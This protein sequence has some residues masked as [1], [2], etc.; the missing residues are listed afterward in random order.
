MVRYY[1]LRRVPLV[2][3]PSAKPKI[4]PLPRAW[5][6][7]EY[8]HLQDLTPLATA[9]RETA[10]KDFFVRTPWIESNR[11]EK[12]RPKIEFSKLPFK[13]I[14]QRITPR[15]L[16]REFGNNPPLPVDTPIG[17]RLTHAVLTRSTAAPPRPRD[18]CPNDC[19]MVTQNAHGLKRPHKLESVIDQMIERNLQAY[20][21]QET[22]LIGDWTKTVKGY[23][24]FHH[25]LPTAS[26][27]R[28]SC[29]VMIILSP[30]LIKA[31]EREGSPPPITA[32]GDT[33]A[34]GR[35]IGVT[36]SFPRFDLQ[37]RKLKGK[38]K[39]L[40]TSAYHPVE[41]SEQI[42]FND[43]LSVFFSNAPQNAE[44]LTGCD[45]NANVGIRST[46]FN[47]EIGPFGL[48]N[49]NAKGV[50]LNN[51]LKFHNF[52]ILLSF[53]Q[54]KNYVT[55]KSFG[56]KPSGH[57]LDNWICC[58]KFRKRVINCSVIDYGVESDHSA[59]IVLFR[60]KAIKF[61]RT[62]KLKKAINWR[63]LATDQVVK[64]D[65]N[66]RLKE[67]LTLC[68]Q[69]R[70]E[71]DLAYHEY[72][73]CIVQAAR[74]TA[75]AKKK[76][77]KGWYDHSRTYLTP[78]IGD[79]TRLLNMIRNSHD[80]SE[81]TIIFLKGMLKQAQQKVHD[82][83]ALAKAKWSTVQ[84][85]K[86][87]NM[88]RNPKDAWQ[89]IKVI[90]AGLTGHHVHPT[91]MRMKMPTGK[92]AT[93][94]KEN[95]SI[96]GPH[97]DKVYNAKRPVDWEY[98]R[99]MKKRKK[100]WKLDAQITWDEFKQAINDLSYDKAA[101]LNKV[102]P[103]ALKALVNENLTYLFEFCRSFYADKKD[104]DEWHESQVCPLPKPGK[105]TSDPNNWRGI[106]LMDMG[107]KVFSSMMCKRAFVLIRKYG[108]K[109]QFGSTPNV[110][111]QDG[112][113]CIKTMLH[114][115]HQHNLPTFVMFADLVKAF[116]TANHELLMEILDTYG[117]PPKFVSAIKRMY[118]NTKVRLIIGKIDTSIP[119]TVGVKQGDS[120]A[121]VLFL[122]L[123]MAF[124]E[125]LEKEWDK[126]KLT[127]P[128]FSRHD[129]SPHTSAQLTAHSLSKPNSPSITR[130]HLFCML[131]VDDGAFTFVSRRELE[132]GAKLIFQQFQKFGLEMHIGRGSKS[133]KTECI[134]FPEPGRF[135]APRL[136]D[137]TPNTLSHLSEATDKKKQENSV[138]KR[139]REDSEYTS[140]AETADIW[141]AD[142][143]I[144][145]TQ[146]FKYL[147]SWLSY[148][149]GDDHDV[150]ERIASANK[151][152]GALRWFWKDTKVD[153]HSKFLTFIAIPLNLLLWGCE[154]W[155]LKSTLLASLEVFLHRSIRSI[156]G[157]TMLQVRE[158]RMSNKK[159]RK[160]FYNILTIQE[161]IAKRQLTFI[162]KITRRDRTHIPTL[163]LT[164]WSENPRKRGGI[165]K[166]NRKSIVENLQLLLPDKIP[167]TGALNTWVHLAQDKHYWNHL[168]GRLGS[169]EDSTPPRTSPSPPSPNHRQ[170]SPPA[171]P[172]AR[173]PASP[174]PPVPPPVPSPPH[175]QHRSPP[176]AP[177]SP[178]PFANSRSRPT[179]D[180]AQV[181]KTKR[182][183]LLF[184][185]LPLSASER[186]VKV[187]YRIL[188]RI[189]HPD[190]HDSQQNS[191]G[192]TLSQTVEH[193]QHISNAHSF[194]REIL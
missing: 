9:R 104:Y 150:A 5:H 159:L 173:P 70:P 20:C 165:R 71:H 134:Y 106:C 180:I 77:N 157:V 127:K 68:K 28:G 14:L 160:K 119:F 129:V 131:Y 57:M 111:C 110:G 161:E 183:S 101:G 8:N 177:P 108:I 10:R 176:P 43:S 33:H 178:A 56:P 126:A 64:N 164:S 44:I 63:K 140:C 100:V 113:F 69:N 114:N 139:K 36:V 41:P 21:L 124:A 35:I 27:N 99:A 121:P 189:F 79:K 15:I 174:P 168:L 23:M 37:N 94:D 132:R 22:W 62:N 125:T 87:H 102:S 90:K 169:R 93:T 182:D 17:H 103:N 38:I 40:I 2:R 78:V 130:F 86:I 144:T 6:H 81:A 4:N 54:H 39:I 89:A 187:R 91:I 167:N 193:F 120:M 29:G 115:R 133:S 158:E 12:I 72:M 76:E 156:L 142:G 3:I 141:V 75:T 172:S 26:C 7:P 117:G 194:L 19:K 179:F 58:E 73:E 25:G 42:L 107:A 11:V 138:T 24:V 98:A 46:R 80:L 191:T 152:M 32:A 128:R 170:P 55:W 184:L 181:G 45:I 123:V 185:E 34:I 84:A 149:L 48:D 118:A 65:F 60:I 116:D 175:Q 135:P 97:L 85:E 151:A 49:R 188:A 13:K 166:T 53:F 192:M 66:N 82:A 163:L 52:K 96:F 83:V 147:G 146:H 155:A 136:I 50:K 30:M 47:Q 67:L 92:L 145:F 186:D 95:A 59:T 51:L 143:I 162:G 137:G 112:T 153:K 190:K 16:S 1:I 61:V 171:S 74:D 122:F 105:D 148:W 18:P 109:Y 31:W 154:S 88:N